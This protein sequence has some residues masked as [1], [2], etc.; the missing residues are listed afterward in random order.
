[1][2]SFLSGHSKAPML[3]WP[4]SPIITHAFFCAD[5]K[6]TTAWHSSS[7]RQATTPVWMPYNTLTWGANPKWV[8]KVLVHQSGAKKGHET[9]AHKT[10]SGQL[11]H[12]SSRSGARTKRFMCLGL[13]KLSETLAHKALSGQLGHRSSRSGARTKRF[14]FLGLRK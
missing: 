11:G 1:M 9:L 7:F 14:V 13:R 3:H 2:C 5:S 10:L 12:Q 4:S 6:F 8:P